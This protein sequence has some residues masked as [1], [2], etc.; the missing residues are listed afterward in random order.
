[1]THRVAATTKDPPI[2]KPN[3][4]DSI[5]SNKMNKNPNPT[6]SHDNVG[7]EVIGG[8]EYVYETDRQKTDFPVT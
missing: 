4:A 7:E 2:P 6:L 8:Y 5:A 1:M 3:V